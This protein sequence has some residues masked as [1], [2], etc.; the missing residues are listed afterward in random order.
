MQKELLE[1]IL[2]LHSHT[3]KSYTSTSVC[4][5]IDHSPT[6]R[7]STVFLTRLRV[8]MSQKFKAIKANKKKL[9]Q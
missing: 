2:Q 1:L 5:I 9:K 6:Y 3:I 4:R 7:S 8:K